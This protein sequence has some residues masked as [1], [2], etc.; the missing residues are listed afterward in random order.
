MPASGT[1]TDPYMTA[2]EFQTRLTDLIH[3]LEHGIRHAQPDEVVI[4]G[5]AYSPSDRAIPGAEVIYQHCTDEQWEETTDAIY[6]TCERMGAYW[7][8]GMLRRASQAT[9]DNGIPLWVVQLGGP[10]KT[11]TVAAADKDAAAMRAWDEN[12]SYGMCQAIVEPLIEG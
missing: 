1:P 12:P 8:D 11:V 6:E 3:T 10:H 5:T 7:D 9:D 4:D 2:P